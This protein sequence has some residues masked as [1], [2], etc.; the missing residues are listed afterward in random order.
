MYRT[1]L[2]NTTVRAIS[3]F[4][5]DRGARTT[6]CLDGTPRTSDAGGIFKM[7]SNKTADKKIIVFSTAYLPLVGGAELAVK[8][9]TDRLKDFKFDLVCARLDKNLP[10]SERLGSVGVYRVGFG[11]ASDKYLLPFGGCLKARRLAKKTGGYAAIWAIMASYGGFAALFYKLSHP[12]VP[13]LLTLQEGDSESHILKRVGIFYFLWKKI[14]AKADYVQAISGYLADFGRRHGASCPAEIVPNGVDLSAFPKPVIDEVKKARTIVTTSRLVPKN[15]VDLLIKA[16]ALLKNELP[17]LKVL[18]AGS[19][20][21][22]EELKKTAKEAGVESI[23][24]FL[25]GVA[26]EKIPE[27]LARADIFVRASRS[28]GLG[29]SFLEAMAAG[30][31]VIGTPVGGIPDFLKDGETGL[32]VK[33]DDAE[34]LAR[35]LKKLLDDAGLRKKLAENGRRLVEEKYGWDA[36]AF[37][38]AAIF[39]KLATK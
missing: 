25:G 35:R 33:V 2:K 23:V 5:Q 6:V 37:K 36:V 1:H 26:P 10:A 15:G 39:N 31:P 28:E 24:E 13:L 4:P 22:E 14:F 9:I 34:D 12:S 20:H 7:G 29:N 30:L 27:I 17:D 19:G 32:M 21:Q 11:R 38:M 16:A 8:E 3:Q 18:I